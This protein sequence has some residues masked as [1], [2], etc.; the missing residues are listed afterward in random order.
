MIGALERAQR[1]LISKGQI[2]SCQ[3]LVVD[4]ASSDDTPALL[5]SFPE[6]ETIRLFSRS[7]YGSA[8]KTGI[9]RAR[10]DL[11]AFMDLD[12]TYDP[13]DI[14]VLLEEKKRSGADFVL[15]ERLSAGQGMPFIRGLGNLFFTW[16]VKKLYKYPIKDACTGFRLFDKEWIP[17]ILDLP[18]DGLDYSLAI[19]LW[20]LNDGLHF[21]E[22]P[23]RYHARSGQSKLSVVSDGIKFFW[24]ILNG[25][26]T[27]S[28]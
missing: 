11:V 27:R 2:S 22:V 19:T 28:R 15:G 17:K 16:L 25:H 26:F 8:I 9:A 12:G 14:S 5:E 10:G 1:A 24:T 3:I 21:S 4:D 7:G 23:I 18:N 20:A 13:E 6:V